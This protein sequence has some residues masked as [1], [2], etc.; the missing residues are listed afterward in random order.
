VLRVGGGVGLEA[1]EGLEVALQRRGE[2]S[3]EGGLIGEEEGEGV[4]PEAAGEGVDAA[5]TPGGVAGVP[6]DGE[7]DGLE[8]AS[9]LVLAARV[10]VEL[11]EGAAG[12][13]FED[14][15]A[16][17]GLQRA[18][19]PGVGEGLADGALGA[20]VSED[21]GL[22]GLLDEALGEEGAEAPPER[23]VRRGEHEA[24]GLAVEPVDGGEVGEAEVLARPG[25][26]IGDAGVVGGVDGDARRLVEGQEVAARFEEARGIVERWGYHG[27]SP[28][29]GKGM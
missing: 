19:A 5:R 4:E 22:V 17:G 16:G 25:H 2:G 8:V 1:P 6:D 9:E 12:E 28:S 13:G 15:V 10:R 24:G 26:Q 3:G 23:R 7:A 29:W 21:E 18:P 20:R 27:A 11:E 14:G